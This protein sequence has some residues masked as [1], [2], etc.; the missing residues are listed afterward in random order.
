MA[1]TPQPV[2]IGNEAAAISLEMKQEC[3]DLLDIISR[4]KK[5]LDRQAGLGLVF[6][7]SVVGVPISNKDTNALSTLSNLS[8]TWFSTYKTNLAQGAQYGG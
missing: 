3:R 1:F 8:T 7:G 4:V 2:D 5:T 6:D